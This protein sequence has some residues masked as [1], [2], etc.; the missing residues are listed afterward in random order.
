MFIN[1]KNASFYYYTGIKT[2]KEFFMSIFTYNNSYTNHHIGCR[3]Y[4]YH[5]QQITYPGYY[6]HSSIFC[7]N[8]IMTRT[9]QSWSNYFAYPQRPLTGRVHTYSTVQW[10]FP[11]PVVITVQ[12]S[13]K[14]FFALQ[15]FA[16]ALLTVAT[17]GMLSAQ[18]NNKRR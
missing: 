6:A 1:D 12:V 15:M 3:G 17:L 8:G 14:A 9:Y 10:G 18:S 4:H 11:N 7:N 2:N 13:K 5:S 16:L